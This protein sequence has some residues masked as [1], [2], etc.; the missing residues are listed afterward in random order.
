[1]KNTVKKVL[2]FMRFTGI[3]WVDHAIGAVLLFALTV[4]VSYK[5]LFSAETSISLAAVITIIAVFGLEI[6]QGET[7]NG[8]ISVSDMCSGLITVW[9]SLPFCMSV[10]KLN[11][12]AIPGYKH[13][14]IAP[15]IG[16]SGFA[17]YYFVWKRLPKK[18]K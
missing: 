14:V 11:G 15:V 5:W 7:K 18:S 13:W 3:D 12:V 4:F 17:W 1:M 16:L 6:W 8:T 2:D 10:F 9:V